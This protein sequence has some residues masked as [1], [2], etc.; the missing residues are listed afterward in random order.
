MTILL[1]GA[2]GNFGA[3]FLRQATRPVVG[4]GREGWDRLDA[5]LEGVDTVVHAAADL[6]TRAAAAPARLMDSNIMSTA[7]LLEAAREAR[8]GRFVFLSSC[9]VYGE[10]M[11]TGEEM[12][13]CPISINGVA[14]L[15]NEKM[16]AEFCAANGIAFQILRVFNTYGGNDRFSILSRLA[17][18]L[19]SGEAFTL[20]NR[21]RMQRD[22][23]HVRDVARI[24]VRLLDCEVRH[25]HLNIGTGVATR[26]ST[27][28]DIVRE[29]FP[30]LQLRDGVT[31]EAEYSRADITRLGGYLEI[32]FVR[33]EDYLRAEFDPLAGA[34]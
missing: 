26:I 9:A 4:L 14:K 7:R 2:S 3:E 27:L 19:R 22:F 34:G 28:V 29:R 12:P 11:R 25:S 30:Q 21:G 8:V 17:Q 6:R 1:T 13:C 32:D 10:D 16:V 5:A 33:I 15:L 24:V 18:A 31:E 23:I 20:N